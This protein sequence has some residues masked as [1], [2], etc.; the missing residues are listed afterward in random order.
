MASAWGDSW[1]NSWGSSWGETAPDPGSGI[2]NGGS[3]IEFPYEDIPKRTPIL[4][5]FSDTMAMAILGVVAT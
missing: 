4:A 1:G 3:K 2:D 5:G